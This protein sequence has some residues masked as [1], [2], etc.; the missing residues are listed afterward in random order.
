VEASGFVAIPIKWR[1]TGIFLG[2]ANLQLA[3]LAQAQLHSPTPRQSGPNQI[4]FGFIPR[5][6]DHSPCPLTSSSR[7][8]IPLS[9]LPSHFPSL[10]PTLTH[11]RE[12]AREM[13]RSP[14][15]MAVTTNADPRHEPAPDD[16]DDDDSLSDTSST[17]TEIAS[18]EFPNF[19]LER[20][21]RLF[22]SYHLFPSHGGPSY[23]FPV[24]GPELNVRVCRL[25]PGPHLP[26][27]SSPPL[28]PR[29]HP[30]LWIILP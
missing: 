13:D 14:S 18:Q 11:H 29:T 22:P 20:D 4:Y 23:P 19:F 2:G 5:K 21:N 27:N 10:T 24:D 28:D 16:E 8:A 1:K 7:C 26:A 15:P 25:S 9:P 17:L 6:N 30:P 3:D 12:Q